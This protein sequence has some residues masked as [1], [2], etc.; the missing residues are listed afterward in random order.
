MR[1]GGEFGRVLAIHNVRRGGGKE[2]GLL[3]SVRVTYRFGGGVEGLGKGRLQH[4][5][6]SEGGKSI[7]IERGR[8]DAGELVGR[9][10]LEG[11]VG[12]DRTRHWMGHGG[13][14]SRNRGVQ[15][16]G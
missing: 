5:G 4:P 13:R 6:R 12:I 9:K 2:G 14:S 11:I 8:E 1:I 15:H 10:G 7:G 3:N 16:H